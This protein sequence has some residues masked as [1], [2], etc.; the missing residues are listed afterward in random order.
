VSSFILPTGAYGEP[1][2]LEWDEPCPLALV[3]L[4]RV[5]L[6]PIPIAAPHQVEL[7]RSIRNACRAG[8]S[9]HTAPISREQQAR[10]WAEVAGKIVAY[11][12]RDG[13]GKH[14]GYGL[15][16]QTE[17]GRWWSSVAVLPWHAGHGYG[18]AI[19]RHIIRQSPAGVV[20]ASARND[21]QAALRLHCA[22]DWEAIGCDQDLTYFRTRGGL[23]P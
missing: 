13:D 18:G 20:W 19:T 7:L 9:T 16:R 17:D 6:T 3:V 14:P 11:L 15:L 23:T 8:F 1:L 10:W 22:A 4:D 12:Y 21:N 2:P 5:G